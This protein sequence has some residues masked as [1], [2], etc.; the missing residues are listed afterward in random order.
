MVIFLDNGTGGVE[1]CDILM[2][3]EA[4]LNDVGWRV[5]VIFSESVTKLLVELTLSVLGESCSWFE[6]VEPLIRV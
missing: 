4:A 5:G 2:D 3:R 1:G 6:V